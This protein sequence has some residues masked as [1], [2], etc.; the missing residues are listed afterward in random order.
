MA[1]TDQQTKEIAKKDNLDSYEEQAH[2]LKQECQRPSTTGKY[3]SSKKS[4]F[5]CAM[6]FLHKKGQGP[7]IDKECHQ[8][9]KQGHFARVC[10]RTS[11]F[12]SSSKRVHKFLERNP[13]SPT[14]S[15]HSSSDPDSSSEETFTLRQTQQGKH[16][17]STVWVNGVPMKMMADSG[18]SVN[19][20]GPE[21]FKL[22]TKQSKETIF[23]KKASTKLL[24]FGETNSIPLLGKEIQ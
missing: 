22:L 3:P 4:C 17:Y 11:H 18:A 21:D 6:D 9:H 24:A 20:L 23:L 1:R 19:V 10:R 2:R 15:R 12:S 7:A 13:S 8:R 5:R 16:P 14:S